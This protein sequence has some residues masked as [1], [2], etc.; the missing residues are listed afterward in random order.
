MSGRVF[1]EDRWPLA[2]NLRRSGSLS[3]G[4]VSTSLRQTVLPPTSPA[5][6]QHKEA[7]NVGIALDKR[8]GCSMMQNCIV[9][10]GLQGRFNAS[11]Q[12]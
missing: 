11:N 2:T 7:E 3:A 5:D 9:H 10:A 12:L 8:Q 4:M 1:G 6:T